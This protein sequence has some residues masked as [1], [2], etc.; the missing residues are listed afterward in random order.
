MTDQEINQAFQKAQKQDREAF[1]LIYDH[2]SGKLYKF[3]FFR[4]GH[5]ELADVLLADTFVKA[6]TKIETLATAQAFAGWLYQIAKNNII[7]YYRVKKSTID[8]NE[9]A[10]LLEDSAS[11]VDEANLKME[12]RV[13]LQLLDQLPEDQQQVIQYKFFE[14]L[15][16]IEIAHIMGKSEGSIRVIQHRAINRLKEL[17]KNKRTRQIS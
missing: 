16:N 17:L 4:V 3:I 12:H 11:P 2:F 15:D 14:D 8:L 13:L 5:K 6:W 10:E 9:V 1:G 7:D